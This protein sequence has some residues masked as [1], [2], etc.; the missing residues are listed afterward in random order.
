MFPEIIRKICC[1]IC[2]Q[3]TEQAVVAPPFEPRIRREITMAQLYA[4]LIRK[5]PGVPIYLSRDF[6]QMPDMEDIDKFVELD[7]TNHF[8]YSLHKYRCSDYTFRLMGQF[9]IPG[10][11]NLTKGFVWT[12]KHALMVFIDQNGDAWWLEPQ[13]D[14]RKSSLE[15]WQGSQLRFIMM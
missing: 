7:N 12:G 13:T 11:N 6:Y 14:V 15:E 3:A 2:N 1:E 9:S 5:F 8:A 4:I 10:W